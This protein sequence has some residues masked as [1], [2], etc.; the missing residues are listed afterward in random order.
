MITLVG[1]GFLSPELQQRRLSS[2]IPMENP[3]GVTYGI[4]MME[5][6]GF[7]GHNGSLPGY[8]SLMIHSPSKNCTIVIWYNSQLADNPTNL[9]TII[10]HLIYSDL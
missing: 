4:G 3:W 7:Y 6:N 5:Y 10:P 9:L 8:T 2:M 1:G